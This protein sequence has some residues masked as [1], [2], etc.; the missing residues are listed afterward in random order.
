[1]PL[2]TIATPTFELNV[3]STGELVSYRPFL[4]KEEKL[5]LMA[6]ESSDPKEMTKV[7]QRVLN[8]CISSPEDFDTTSLAMFDLEYIFL[9]LR[10][11][12][13]GET[14]EP[15]IICE[16]CKQA[17]SFEI[18]LSAIEVTFDK[19]HTN[20][21]P[22]T[23]TVGVIMKYPS[24][25]TLSEYNFTAGGEN[26]LESTEVAFETIINCI[27][28]IYD[29]EQKYSAKDQTKEELNA[30]VEGLTQG[31]FLKIQ[32]FFDTMPKLE[33]TVTYT[34]PCDGSE[35]QFTLSSLADF[36]G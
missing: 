21:I 36:F 29:A 31:Q 19:S 32:S 22:L 8:D 26:P 9:Q 12:S 16:P 17:V 23:D 5:L 13:I 24:F 30:F 10:A 33:H 2:P 15:Q 28:Y 4:V 3:P 20:H 11:R 6:V 7:F 34:N 25:D 35:Q 14:V 27:D 18:D 1:M